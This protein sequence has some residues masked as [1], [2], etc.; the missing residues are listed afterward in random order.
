MSREKRKGKAQ[1]GTARGAAA[2]RHSIRRRKGTDLGPWA[3]LGHG[4]CAEREESA[5]LR[6]GRL[7][8][9]GGPAVTWE[10]EKK[11]KKKSLKN[12]VEKHRIILENYDRASS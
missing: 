6:W 5:K 8:S 11:G 10:K 9:A 1:K 4:D 2:L 7:G 3:E 12:Y